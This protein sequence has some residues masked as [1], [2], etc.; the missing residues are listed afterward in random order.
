M[1]GRIRELSTARNGKTMLTLEIN[2]RAAAETLYDE[3]NLC[4]KLDI[5]VKKWRDK[6]SL[7]SNAYAWLLLGKLGAKIGIAPE[8]I[9]REMVKDVGD[10]YEILPVRADAVKRF[11]EAWQKK[12]IG[13]LTETFPSKLRGYVNVM[14]YYGSST[15][16]TAQMSRLLELII[17][18]CKAQGIETRPKEEIDAMMQYWEGRN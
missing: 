8:I 1:T 2:E 13:W 16:D 9:Y 12:G 18:E 10:N 17:A 7:D 11:C 15:Y 5:S 6:R 3:L 4:E 14:A